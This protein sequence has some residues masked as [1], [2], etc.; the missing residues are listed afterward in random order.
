MRRLILFFATGAGA[1][2]VPYIPG[3]A[4]TLLAVPLSYLLNRIEA[5]S[6]AVSL[7][8]LAAF[9]AAAAWFCER[10]EE[11]LGKRDSQRI[12]MDEMAGFLV[13]SFLTPFEAVP[14]AL[15]FLLFRFFDIVKLFPAR[16]AEKLRGGL[17]IIADDLV[18]GLY[19]FLVLRL[20]DRLDLL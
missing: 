4:G 1:G 13:A 11:L 6:F 15:A 20:I 17:G 14:T 10:A 16:H 3:T 12:V 7:L 5:V 9:V 2:Y 18:A 8:T 19:A